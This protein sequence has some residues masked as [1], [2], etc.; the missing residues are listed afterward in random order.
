MHLHRHQHLCIDTNNSKQRHQH[1]CTDTNTSTL[2]PIPLDRHQHPYTNTST[3]TPIPLDRHQHPYT[4][5]NISTHIYQHFWTDSNHIQSAAAN[6]AKDTVSCFCRHPSA[7]RKRWHVQVG[8]IKAGTRRAN[9]SSPKAAERLR[10][11]GQVRWARKKNIHHSDSVALSFLLRL[12]VLF[13]YC[14]QASYTH[15]RP[16]H[17]PT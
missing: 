3:P 11:S 10:D 6:R 5:T 1:F 7:G 4:D 9:K 16:T 13:L 14:V 2:T 8:V 12:T 15:A 17:V